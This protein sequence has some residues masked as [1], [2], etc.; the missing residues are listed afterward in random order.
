MI[1]IVIESVRYVLMAIFVAYCS[2]C[3][4]GTFVRGSFCRANFLII[5]EIFWSP[6]NIERLVVNS[7]LSH[8]RV[9][10]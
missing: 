4:R 8:L 7:L 5:I 9:W 2:F 6:H 1:N 10:Q 3:P